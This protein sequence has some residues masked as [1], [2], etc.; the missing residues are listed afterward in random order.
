MTS[1]HSEYGALTRVMVQHARDAFVSDAHIAAQWK[2][3]N[4]SAPPDFSLAV[5]EYDRFLE[6]L[7]GS[8]AEI[9]FLPR[10]DS[11]TLDSIYTRDASVL[12]T[13]GVILCRMGKPARAAEP[14]AQEP[15]LR[16]QGCSVMGAIAGHGMLEGGDLVW[17]DNRTVMVGEG[18]RTNAEGIRQL[19]TF[20][21]DVR[22]EL[23]VVPLPE[24]S[25][26]HDVLHLMSLI[27]PIDK[28]LAL[29]YPALLP[30]P[31]R[32]VLRNRGFHLIDVPDDEFEKMGTNVLAL[33]P[34][35]CVMLDGNSGTRAALERAGARVQVYQGTEISVKGGGGPTCLTRP[36]ARRSE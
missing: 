12:G 23:L 34:R 6:I 31:S 7:A 28:D 19:R 13:D 36:L 15:V 5:D 25:S 21:G 11:L 8:G 27:S 2:R 17:L 18:R 33:A 14:C 3:L 30:S 1:G 10:H 35:D 26:Q 29:V 9:V 20:L 24:Y 4:Y 22:V 16:D 32:A